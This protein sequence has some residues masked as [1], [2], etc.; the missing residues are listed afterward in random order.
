M[1]RQTSNTT[2]EP[3]DF[4]REAAQAYN[5]KYGL[6]K[7]VNGLYVVVDVSRARKI[8]EAYEVLPVDDTGNPEV[9]NAFHQ[10]AQEIDQQWN[11]AIETMRI[12][13]EPWKFNGQPYASNSAE[14]CSDIR[15]HHHLY[16]YQGGEPHPLLGKIDSATCFSLNEKFRAIHD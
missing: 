1:D 16:F 9:R 8:A 15:S 3:N 4:V 2:R 5:H 12:T 14:M 7:I 11:F 6:G 10:L 13:L